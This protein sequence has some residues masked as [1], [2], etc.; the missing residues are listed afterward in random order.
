[1]TSRKKSEGLIRPF[2][3]EPEAYQAMF[4]S[5]PPEKLTMVVSLLLPTVNRKHR[6]KGG[7]HR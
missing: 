5:K 7:N 3:V 1:M 6:R 4:A 2:N